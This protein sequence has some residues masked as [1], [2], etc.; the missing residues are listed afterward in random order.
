MVSI[1]LSV[2]LSSICM[3]VRQ[4]VLVFC[5]SSHP[6]V[7]T[8]TRMTTCWVLGKIE[9]SWLLFLRVKYPRRVLMLERRPSIHPSINMFN[10]PTTQP[11]TH[12][13]SIYL[14]MLHY[15]SIHPS[16]YLS[17]YAALKVTSITK[18]KNKKIAGLIKNWMKIK[19]WKIFGSEKTRGGGETTRVWGAKRLGL[20]I[21]AKRLGGK[22]LGGET[23]SYRFNGSE[24]QH[25]LYIKIK[26]TTKPRDT[27]HWRVSGS[28]TG[29]VACE[30][31]GPV[32]DPETLPKVNN[33]QHEQL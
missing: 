23:S 25:I 8:H 9:F 27:P 28:G 2:C 12:H 18:T 16:I 6:S 19:K 30:S 24:Y 15:P 13:L 17:I 20:K 3:C 26:C 22:R 14:S 33:F 29:P 31:R 21:E 4:N 1:Y 10:H 32:L 11:S 5:L 7:P